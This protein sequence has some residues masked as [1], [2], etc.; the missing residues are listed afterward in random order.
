[1][2]KRVV[3]LVL[4]FLLPVIHIALAEE[5]V[6][7]ASELFQDLTVNND[8][9]F[10][11]SGEWIRK[12]ETSGDQDNDLVCHAETWNR[13]RNMMIFFV[14]E[15]DGDHVV[16]LAMLNDYSGVATRDETEEL[17]GIKIIYAKSDENQAAYAYLSANN[18]V[19]SIV[20]SSTDEKYTAEKLLE[21]LKN[22]V[23]TI[24][25]NPQ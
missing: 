10:S 24:S 20:V 15:G 22:N 4:V 25:L 8:F 12:E 5:Q 19:Y 1:M 23:R 2:L 11:V 18:H 21:E 17:G 14:E 9:T 7:K 13:D 3:C 6:P 16:Q